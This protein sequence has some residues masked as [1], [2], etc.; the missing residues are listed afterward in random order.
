[1]GRTTSRS[2]GF[3]LIELLVV[4]TIIIALMGMLV[5][6]IGMIRNSAKSATSQALVASLVVA[7]RSYAD[8]DPRHFF[9]TPAATG[10][11]LIYDP[12]D[13]RATLTMMET[14]GYGIPVTRL[15]PPGATPARELR[16]G[17]DRA[18]RYR[19]DGPRLGGAGIDATTMDGTA[20]KPAPQ[21][22][23]NPRGLE[24]Y[25]YLWSVGK[26][27]G[28]ETADADPAAA[29]RWLYERGTP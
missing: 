24:P 25:A 2:A 27:S 4:I 7:M 22:D 20:T 8:E 5:P 29:G 6:V 23:W 13:P 16:D 18:V 19:L 14:R 12:A 10:D 21:A 11:R 3:S 1:M 15:A 28:D 9:P 26:P 17:W